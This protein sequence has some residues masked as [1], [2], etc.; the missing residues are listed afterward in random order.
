MKPNALSTVTVLLLL[1][2]CRSTDPKSH[3]L[4]AL[5][6]LPKPVQLAEAVPLPTPEPQFECMKSP[7]CPSDQPKNPYQ[8]VL[9]RYKEQYLW[10]MERLQAWGSTPCE[11]MKAFAEL[12]CKENKDAK[13]I[14]DVSCSPDSTGG[15]CPIP[16]NPCQETKKPSKCYA[17]SYEGQDL[18]WDQR[19][20][21]WGPNEC[22]AKNR[23]AQLACRMGLNPD[24]FGKIECEADT[25]PGLCPPPTP[26]CSLEHKEPTECLVS[27]I[28]D[29]SLKKPWT[30]IGTSA[31]EAQ[32]RLQQLACLFGNSLNQLTPQKLGS[33]EC[34]GLVV[35]APQAKPELTTPN[36][37]Q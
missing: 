31:C 17:K 4:K 28:G 26:R 24:E 29:I 30:A 5:D 2:S 36:G 11:A 14:Q 27:Q 9:Y 18:T 22:E 33:M 8:C 15:R 16:S 10:E 21:A 32:Y 7:D 6:T 25:N 3:Q 37:G 35:T 19:P 1:L 20:T 34:R 23:L 12:T 13:F